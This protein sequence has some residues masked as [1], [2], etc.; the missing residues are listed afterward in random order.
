TAGFAN[1]AS[2]FLEANG[3]RI[4]QVGQVQRPT[5]AVLAKYSPQYPCFTQALVDWRPR[6]DEAFRDSQFHITVEVAPQRPGYTPG[7]E[8]RWGEHRPASC[9]LLPHPRTSQARP[10]PGKKFD[11]GT[12]NVGGYP[13]NPS[14]S[15]LPSMFAG[16]SGA[17]VADPDAGLAG[18]T[19]EQAV[20]GALLDPGR[21]PSAITTLLAG[22]M[23]RG[24]TVS[25]SPG[26]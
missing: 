8:P 5:L 18:T 16:P 25:Q 14:F 9:G 2:D 15:A 13:S 22:P 24:T 21:A 6:I 17:A 20:V 7:E 1:E 11:D 26:R 10:V 23:L 19:Q 3:G 4:I 12:D